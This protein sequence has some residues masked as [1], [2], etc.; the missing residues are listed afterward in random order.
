[1]QWSTA[2]PVTA[3]DSSASTLD[4]V[5]GMKIT[6]PARQVF[7]MSAVTKLQAAE[8]YAAVAD[9]LLPFVQPPEIHAALA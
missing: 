2:L 9:W 3:N 8:C 5:T 6:R 1:M 7:V 4:K